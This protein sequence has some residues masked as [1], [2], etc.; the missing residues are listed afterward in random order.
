MSSAR[1]IAPFMPSAPGVRTICAPNAA[2]S[3]RRSMLIVSGIVRQ[4]L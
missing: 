1:L 2:S 3:F 4:S